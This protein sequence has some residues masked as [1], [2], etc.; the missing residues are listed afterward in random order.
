MDACGSLIAEL[1][2]FVSKQLDNIDKAFNDHLE[3]ERVRMV[4]NSDEY[5]SVFRKTD[6]ETLISE[7]TQESDTHSSTTSTSSSKCADAEAELAAK[8]EQA[9]AM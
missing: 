1:C 9:K 8:L 4:L 7:S 3:E 5:G 2:E 6:T